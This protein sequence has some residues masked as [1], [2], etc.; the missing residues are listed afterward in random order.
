MKTRLWSSGLFN[1]VLSSFSLTSVCPS[2]CSF[3]TQSVTIGSFALTEDGND[4]TKKE[5]TKIIAI[6]NKH[7]F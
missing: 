4:P 7:F 2:G 5:N 3:S 6:T 1:L